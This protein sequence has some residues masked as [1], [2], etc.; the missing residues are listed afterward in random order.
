MPV[1]L[2]IKEDPEALA[3][4]LRAFDKKLCLAAQAHLRDLK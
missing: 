2:S 1:D 4:R 3:E